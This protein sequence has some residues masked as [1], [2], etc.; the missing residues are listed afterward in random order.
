LTVIWHGGSFLNLKGPGG[1]ALGAG[2]APG[3]VVFFGGVQSCKG[4]NVAGITGGKIDSYKEFTPDKE[5]YHG[6]LKGLDIG[7]RGPAGV[8]KLSSEWFSVARGE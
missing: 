6:S 1:L 4:G 2:V 8:E 7:W 3:S 5:V